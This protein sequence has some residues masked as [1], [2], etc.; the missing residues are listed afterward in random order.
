MT[1]TPEQTAHLKDKLIAEQQ[2]LRV[3]ISALKQ[4]EAEKADCSLS[5]SADAA[6][7][8]ERRHR[9]QSLRTHHEATLVEIDAA[10]ARLDNGRYGISTTSGEP[11][12][13]ERLD[14]VPWARTE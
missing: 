12:P 4:T 10:L 8:L 14:L 3:E 13:L 7:Y 2:K 6:A 9:A 11:I 5:D 1:L